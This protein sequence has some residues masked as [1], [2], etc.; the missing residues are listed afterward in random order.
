MA[1]T[2]IEKLE[3]ADQLMFDLNNSKKPKDDILKVGQLLKEVGVLQE[4]TDDLNAIVD[5]YNQNA[6]DEIKKAIRKRMVATVKL[7]LKAIEPYLNSTDNVTI[8]FV[9]ECLVNFK[10]YGQIV[11]RFNDKKDT[12]KDE[13]S[14][15]NYQQAFHEIDEKRHY[16]HN[17]CINSIVAINRMIY[18]DD[19]TKPLFATWDNSNVEKVEDIPRSDIGNAIL[20]LHLEVLMQNE[21]NVLSK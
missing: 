2:D 14:T 12:W 21:K 17:D 1:S 13:K 8:G 4:S 18:L 3:Q 5:A 11:L 6:R 16:I 15:P 10:Q 9:N 19:P 20:E 7:N